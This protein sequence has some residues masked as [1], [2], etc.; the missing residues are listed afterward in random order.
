VEAGTKYLLSEQSNVNSI[1]T[2][3]RTNSIGPQLVFLRNEYLPLGIFPN[4]HKLREYETLTLF[5][6]HR[7]DALQ[8]RVSLEAVP[9]EV[10]GLIGVLRDRCGI[11]TRCDFMPSPS[12]LDTRAPNLDF[13]LI[14]AP[15]FVKRRFNAVTNDDYDRFY[16]FHQ[17]NLLM[18]STNGEVEIYA[19]FSPQDHYC[20]IVSLNVPIY[21]LAG[22]MGGLLDQLKEAGVSYIELLLGLQHGKS[23][24]AASEAGFI[25]SAIYPAMRENAD[26]KME[27][28][29]VLS[30]TLEPLNFRGMSIAKEFKPYVDQYVNLW[31][32][33]A[34][35][36]LRIIQVEEV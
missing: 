36:S 33:R 5:A 10:S 26:G 2:T 15:E 30:R 21:E 16:P 4:A 20:A 23:I 13:E 29:V 32:K 1:Y 19:F 7:P 28:F 3:T 35:E 24:D 6:R 34:L 12:G 11:D 17:P 8:R 31:K 25:P 22:R 14:H 18:I 9:A 27:D